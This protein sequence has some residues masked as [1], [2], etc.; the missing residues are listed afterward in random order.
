MVIYK[1][2]SGKKDQYFDNKEIA[3][4]LA[5]QLKTKAVSIN[6]MMSSDSP[7]VKYAKLRGVVVDYMN[8]LNNLRGK[9]IQ[10]KG[11]DNK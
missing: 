8:S 2:K 5:K 1:V 3:A 4:Q 6:V 9:R 11:A 10:K 7:E